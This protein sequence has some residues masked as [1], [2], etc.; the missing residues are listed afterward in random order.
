VGWSRFI[1][2]LVGER[3]KQSDSKLRIFQLDLG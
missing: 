2:H 3:S 1:L